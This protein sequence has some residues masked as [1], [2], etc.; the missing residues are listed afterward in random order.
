MGMVDVLNNTA[1]NT[2]DPKYGA[3]VGIVLGSSP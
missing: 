3:D 1:W 2:T